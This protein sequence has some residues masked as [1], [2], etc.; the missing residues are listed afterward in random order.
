[1]HLLKGSRIAL[2]AVTAHQLRAVL[3]I[4]GIVVGVAAVISA[5]KGVLSCLDRKPS[6]KA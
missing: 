2:K 3:A 1:M 6:G 5:G 4:L